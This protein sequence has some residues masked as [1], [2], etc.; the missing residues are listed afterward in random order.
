M[1]YVMI[2]YV[3]V[4]LTIGFLW[5]LAATIF[6]IKTKEVPNW[7]NFTLIIVILSYRMFYSIITNNYWVI[8]EGIIGLGVFLVIANALYYA[9]AFGGG[10]AKLLI[11]LG[12]IIWWGENWKVSATNATTFIM[13]LLLIGFLYGITMS[14]IIITKSEKK[15]K[16]KFFEETKKQIK[17]NKKWLIITGI[18]TIITA[19]ISIYYKSP[20]IMI[21]TIILIIIPILLIY[22]KTTEKT[23]LTKKIS[24]K[25]L[26]EGDWLY[27]E[28]RL[29]NGMIIKAKF[30][31]VTKEEI[32][33]IIKN[34]NQVIIRDGIAFVPAF[35]IAY[36]IM[37]ILWYSGW[38]L[39]TNILNLV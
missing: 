15:E 11:A 34:Q 38:S 14:A 10:D 37:A 31:G 32:K 23:I 5:V 8:I 29:K 3:T 16:E 12:T 19:T 33:K 21:I 26:K 35:L 22:S 27:K 2:D 39:L 36:I 20:E 1:V 18:L 13:L 30:D 6:D 9:K 4:L 24:T 7:L 25:E 17:N 28:V